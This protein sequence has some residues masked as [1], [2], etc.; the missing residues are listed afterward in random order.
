MVSASLSIFGLPC[1]TRE[2]HRR[3]RALLKQVGRSKARVLIERFISTAPQGFEAIL[4][5][6][7]VAVDRFELKPSECQP[8]RQAVAAWVRDELRLSGLLA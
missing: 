3:R 2:I 6:V 8:M 5:W 1:A 4:D 7:E